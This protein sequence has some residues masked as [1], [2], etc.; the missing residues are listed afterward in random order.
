[1]GVE[2]VGAAR[3]GLKDHDGWGIAYLCYLGLG[4]EC[5]PATDL[6]ILD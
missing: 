5:R 1:M 4:S 6:K 2:G 3:S